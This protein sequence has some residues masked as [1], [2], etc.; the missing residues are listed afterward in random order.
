VGLVVGRRW[1]RRGIGRALTRVR[2]DHVREQGAREAFY[3]AN[4]Q[5]R[6]S[7]ALHADLGFTEQTRDFHFS[8][9]HFAE[10]GGVLFRV[11]W[12]A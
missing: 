8:A 9:A 2:L 4:E 1:R 5:N 6:A 7:I 3:F 10:G 11:G 12:E